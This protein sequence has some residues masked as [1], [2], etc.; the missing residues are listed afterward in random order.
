MYHPSLVLSHLGN[1]VDSYGSSVSPYNIDRRCTEHTLLHRGDLV[2]LGI[3]DLYA[4][5]LL[6]SHDDL[7][8]IERVQSEIR[9]ESGSWG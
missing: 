2:S 8:S 1:V 5:L 6:D 4:K 9:G 7:D 3:W